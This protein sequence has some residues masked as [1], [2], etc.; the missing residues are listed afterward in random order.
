MLLE[1]VHHGDDGMQ[2]VGQREKKISIVQTEITVKA[3]GC[4]SLNVSAI[5]MEIS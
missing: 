3:A 1:S 4:V 2:S 5:F